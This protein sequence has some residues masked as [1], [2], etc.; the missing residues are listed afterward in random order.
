M[1]KAKILLVDDVKVFLEVQKE[2]LKPSPVQVLTAKNGSE[3]LE[4]A[5]NERPDLVVMDVEMPE[6]DGIECCAAIKN[7][8]VLGSTPVIL[9]SSTSCQDVVESS[10]KAGCD[11]FLQ[12]PVYGREFL[13]L[14]H[15]FLPVVERRRPRVPCRVPVA[16]QCEGVTFQ[17]MTR[18]IGMNGVYVASEAKV[19]QGS[20]IVASFRLPTNAYAM[21]VARGRVA[22]VNHAREQIRTDLPAG[23]GVEFREI[24]GEGVSHLRFCELTEFVNSYKPSEP[25]AGEKS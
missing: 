12:K 18:D 11:K 6:M 7:D 24:T 16:L 8:P 3:A 1:R 23:F 17:G 2:F 10:Y 19:E 22:W 5:R 14:A 20:E 21:T 25:V 15:S 4:I 9:L 13:N